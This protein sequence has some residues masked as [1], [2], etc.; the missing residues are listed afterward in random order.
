MDLLQLNKRFPIQEGTFKVFYNTDC[1]LHV[2][3]WEDHPEKPD[4]LQAILSGCQ[5]AI[6][7]GTSVSFVVP[8]PARWQDLGRVHNRDYLEGMESCVLSGKSSF[9]TQDTYTCPDSLFSILASAGLSLALADELLSGGSGFALTRPPG[10]H[11]G[12]SNAEGFCFVNHVALCIEAISLK[13]PKARVLVVDFDVHYGNGTS[14]IYREDPDVYYFSI[15]GPPAHIYPYSG[16][17]DEKG[18]GKRSGFY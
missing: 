10:H 15:H 13:N 3:S 14:S 12:K 9:M 17:E 1:L 7:E 11:A 6:P 8:T 2:S 16:Y 18:R 4:R 5:E